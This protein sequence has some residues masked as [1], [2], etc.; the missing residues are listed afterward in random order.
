MVIAGAGGGGLAAAVET[1][2]A[3]KEVVVCEVMSSATMSNPALCAGMIQGACT[4]LQKEAGIDDS[5]EEFD[6][7]LTA[8]AGGFENPELRRLYAEEIRRDY[9]LV[10]RAGCSPFRPIACRPR[11][12]GRLLH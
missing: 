2:A 10:G 11:N 1:S 7:Y 12:H 9:R 8:V 3:G 4:K 6:K 5:V